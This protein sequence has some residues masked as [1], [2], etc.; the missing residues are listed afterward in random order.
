MAWTED[1]SSRGIAGIAIFKRCFFLLRFGNRDT[2]GSMSI[3]LLPQNQQYLDQIVASGLYP[4]QEAALNAAIAALREK[5]EQ[6]PFISAKEMEAVEQGIR[7]ADA[8]L[9]RPMTEEDWMRLRKRAEAAAE[10]ARGGNS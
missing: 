5:A 2:I 7:E 8:G 4:S 9:S 6:I 1:R 10:R 3:G